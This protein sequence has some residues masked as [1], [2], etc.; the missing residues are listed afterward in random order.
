MLTKEIIAAI[1]KKVNVPEVESGAFLATNMLT[2]VRA[3]ILST[4]SEISLDM[5]E[6]IDLPDLR[7]SIYRVDLDQARLLSIVVAVYPDEAVLWLDGLS[8]EDFS[9]FWNMERLTDWI[10]DRFDKLLNLLILTRLNYLGFPR[11]INQVDDIPVLETSS[12]STE[13]LELA[14]RQAEQLAGIKYLVD[15][16][17]FT[18][19][20]SSLSLSFLVWTSLYGRLIRIHCSYDANLNFSHK[21]NRLFEQLG[22]YHLPR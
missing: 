3:M 19:T 2:N 20:H 6:R 4:L 18:Q 12:D 17:K 7:S 13:L 21:S 5:V 9:T 1:C 14:H 15:P 16:P 10:A 8:D 11:V 22:D